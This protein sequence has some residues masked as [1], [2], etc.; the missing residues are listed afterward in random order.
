MTIDEAAGQPRRLDVA[1]GFTLRAAAGGDLIEVAVEVALRQRRRV[2][3]GPARRSWHHAL[4]TPSREIECVHE[5]VDDAHRIVLGQVGVQPVRQWRDV[6][7]IRTPDE[8]RHTSLHRHA[9][10]VRTPTSSHGLYPERPS[11]WS[12]RA[13]RR[14]REIVEFGQPIRLSP[15]DGGQ[16]P[17]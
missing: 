7:A 10:P 8:P 3:A 16:Q 2:V 6:V 1:A 17:A 12:S 4:E 5:H 11:K 13:P 14:A 9:E 15:A